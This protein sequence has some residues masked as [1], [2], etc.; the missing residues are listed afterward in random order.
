MDQRPAKKPLPHMQ[1][2]PEGAPRED[3]KPQNPYPYDAKPASHTVTPYG[4]S[5]YDAATAAGIIERA[6]QAAEQNEEE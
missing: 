3:P 1:L 6:K 4:W 5:L 2:I